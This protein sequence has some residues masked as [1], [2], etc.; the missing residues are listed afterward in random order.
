V[1]LGAGT[2]GERYGFRPRRAT[3]HEAIDMTTKS[4]SPLLWFLLLCAAPA[5]AA[6]QTVTVGGV[7]VGGG[8]GDYGSSPVLMFSPA[9]L[10]INVGDTVT[11]TNAGGIHN[12]VSDTPG[13]FRC[14]AGC[15]GAG[16]NGTPSSTDWISSVTFTQAGTFGFHCEVHGA[17]GMSGSITVN[18][19]AAT[20]AI[21]PGITGSWFNPAQSGHGFNVE[22]L[23]N[24][25]F[26][27]FWYV[28]DNKGNNLW[29]NGTGT[30]SGDTVTVNL[31]QV[32]G[33]FFP[34]NFDP[35]K[36]TRPPWG[37]VTFKFTDCSNG[38]AS[39]T[40]LDTTNFSAGTMPISRLTAVDGL[41]CQ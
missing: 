5:F 38:V 14:A 31:V 33:G 32:N 3:L 19:P 16:G 10:T 6:N 21:S 27:T 34:P 2:R 41:A 15:D 1:L 40:P 26:I 11:F 23:P 36:I 24:N 35:T 30:V 28:Y 29:L 8:Y 39:W 4:R 13:L 12:V 20:F 7:T 9:T 22:V 17:M 25:L 18:A 37:T